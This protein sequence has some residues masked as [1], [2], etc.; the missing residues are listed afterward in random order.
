[1]I[2]LV[3]DGARPVKLLNTRQ[4]SLAARRG[5]SQREGDNRSAIAATTAARW[6]LRKK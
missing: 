3:H 6:G 1:M 5:V 2:T 4:Q